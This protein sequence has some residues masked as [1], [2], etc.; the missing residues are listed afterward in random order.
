M[1]YEHSYELAKKIS[2]RVRQPIH[3]PIED[4]LTPQEDAYTLMEI[5]H[6]IDYKFHDSALDLTS[7]GAADNGEYLA[8]I[9]DILLETGII[10][11]NLDAAEALS[12]SLTR[13][14]T[15]RITHSPEVN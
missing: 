2:D 11:F 6:R 14:P 9:L 3:A 15:D 4:T 8:G 7:G 13:P 1:D 5:I 10:V 12:K